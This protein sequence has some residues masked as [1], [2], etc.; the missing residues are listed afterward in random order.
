MV[1]DGI[2]KRNS[3]ASDVRDMLIGSIGL[4]SEVFPN[5]QDDYQFAGNYFIDS[6]TV[7][8]DTI[9]MLM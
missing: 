5:W 1:L 8:E 2:I 7:A 9:R 3:P 4:F 6:A